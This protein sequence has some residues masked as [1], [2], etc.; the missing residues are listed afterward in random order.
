VTDASSAITNAIYNRFTETTRITCW[1]N[2]I[3]NIDILLRSIPSS[4]RQPIR[5]DIVFIQ[6]TYD[7]RVLSLFLKNEGLMYYLIKLK[8]NLINKNSMWMYLLQVLIMLW[9]DVT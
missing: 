7:T 3:R 6:G 9:S 8:N 4:L 1:T 2:V 5:S